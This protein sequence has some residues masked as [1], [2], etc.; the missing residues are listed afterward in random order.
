[1]L[2]KEQESRKLRKLHGG[3]DPV[4]LYKDNLN[5]AQKLIEL[6]S[7]KVHI[8]A[9]FNSNHSDEEMSPETIQSKLVDSVRYNHK[10]VLVSDLILP[11]SMKSVENSQLYMPS[12]TAQVHLPELQASLTHRSQAKT[13]E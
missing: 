1:M 3:E 11:S 13:S 4:R 12:I 2:N 10:K 9:A 7:R 8:K 5:E 6:K